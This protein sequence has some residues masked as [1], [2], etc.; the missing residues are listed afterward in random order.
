MSEKKGTRAV[1]EAFKAQAGKGRP[2][3]V[4]NKATAM[5]KSVIAEAA[6]R[7][8]GVE[9]IIEWVGESPDNEKIFWSSMYTKLIPVQ[10]EVTG[11]DG[12]AVQ[13]EEVSAAARQ[14]TNAISAMAAREREANTVQ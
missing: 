5:A 10:T 9:R 8:G 12:G 1:C 14:F 13:F 11:A 2:K 3:G 4:P 6:E 7:M